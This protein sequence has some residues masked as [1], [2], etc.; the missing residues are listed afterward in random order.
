MNLIQ[1]YLLPKEIDF[2]RALKKQADASRQ[3]V[4]DL[5]DFCLG[6][7]EK[8]LNAI[9]DDEHHS[10]SLKNANMRE[11]LDV[12]ITPY[13]KESIYRMIVQLDWISLSVKHL[14]IDLVAYKVKCP[15]SYE[16]IFAVLSD[17]IKVLTL[18]FDDLS[19]KKLGEILSM[20]EA[21]HDN[22]DETVK[23]CATASVRH[24]EE[25]EIKTYLAH[26]E[27]LHQLKEVSKRI[28]LSAN[29]LED[30]AMKIV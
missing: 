5:A 3:S 13:D 4:K 26:R 7:N 23:L 21:I 8:A 6:N 25:D 22:Y 16:P 30:M 28:H 1:K 10:R 14:A 17:M 18:A 15:A 27:I 24:L 2:N 20:I 11:L 19:Q 9:L 12:F 29:T